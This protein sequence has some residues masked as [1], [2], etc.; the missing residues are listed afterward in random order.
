VS[1]RK[2]FVPFFAASPG[3]SC[4]CLTSVCGN[5]NSLLTH[6]PRVRQAKGYATP[7]PIMEPEMVEV[8]AKTKKRH[9]VAMFVGRKMEKRAIHSIA[10]GIIEE[11]EVA[12]ST[13]VFLTGDSGFGKVRPF[14]PQYSSRKV[15]INSSLSLPTDCL[16]VE[17]F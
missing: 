7:V 6:V 10:T 15:F 9:N 3:E 2:V 14:L 5:C 17:H 1:G 13:M 11:P 12:Q 8:A 16:G 4:S